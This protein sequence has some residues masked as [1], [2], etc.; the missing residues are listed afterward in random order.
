MTTTDVIS[1]MNGFMFQVG[2]VI[3]PII[4]KVA[5]RVTDDWWN[6]VV[7]N[8]LSYLQRKKV[9]ETGVHDL[10]GLDIASLLRVFDRN[11]FVITNHIFIN[12]RV[13]DGIRS[14]Q[15]IR[16]DWA[17]IAPA[18]VTKEKVLADAE[19]ITNLLQLLGSS[20]GEYRG[21]EQFI[22]SVGKLDGFQMDQATDETPIEPKESAGDNTK[23]EKVMPQSGEITLGSVVTIKSDSSKSGA[24]IGVSGNKYSVFVN[25]AVESYYRE[26][27]ELQNVAIENRFMTLDRVKSA[28]TA[29][30]INNPSSSNLYSLNSARVDFVPYQFRPA[31]KMIQS[32]MPRILVADDV[33]VGKTIEAGFILK[34]M[35]ARHELNSVLVICPRP[36]VAERKWEL[37]M[38]RF[39]ENFTQ[40]NGPAFAQ[41]ISDTDRD[42]EWPEMYS[43]TIIPY[44]L[45]NEDSVMG[46]NSTS[47]KKKKQIGLRDLDPPPHFDLVIVDEAHNIRNS[48]TWMYRAVEI[49]CQNAD[50]VV[51]LTATPLQNS[52]NDLYTLLNLLRPDLVI[53][54]DTFA[55]MSEPNQYINQMLRSARSH[56]E[57]WQE[58]CK[59]EISNILGTSWG[60][61][62]IQHNP[63][64]EKIYD[65]LNL[66]DITREQR[67]ELISLIEGLHSFHSI[68]NRTRRQ[69]IEN[70]CVRRNLTVEVP[71]TGKQRE[72]YE[73]LIEFQRT[74]LTM[75]H[76]AKSVRFMMCTIMRQTA[77]CVYGLA[78]FMDEIVRRNLDR[79]DEQEEFI[80]M[81]FTLNSDDQ[82]YILELSDKINQMAGELPEEDPKFD[83]LMV[84]LQEKQKEEN[85]RVILFSSF[86][87]TLYY[88]ENRLKDEGFRVGRVDGS[89]RDEER[90]RLR[91][92]FQLD[93]NNEDA[94]D[95]LLFSEVGC[96]GLDY[97][98]CDTM[99]N[100][101]L[102][103]NPMR[104]EQR[105]GRIDRRGQKS[106]SIKI[107]NLIT[108]DTI[109][110]TIYNRCLMKIG[111]FEQSIGD[112]SE[113]LGDI[114]EQI[115]KIMFDPELSEEERKVKIEKLADN[116]VMK[117]Q[118]LH[119]LEQQEKSLYGFDL[120][121]YVQNKDVQ[122]A[123]NEWISPQ[124]LQTLINLYLDDYLGKGEYLRGRS[125]E[126]NLQIA[127]E[128]RQLLM[129]DFKKLKLPTVSNEAN[130]WWKSFLKQVKTP[131]LR[132][133]F[134][135]AYARDN[136][137]V[138][139][140]T[141]MHP[142]VIQAARY[143][144]KDYPCNL[145]IR[146]SDG[147]LP[148]GDYEFLIYVWKYEG[149]RPDV[150]LVAICDNPEVEANVLS[151]IRL[152]SEYEDDGKDHSASWDNMDSLHYERWS[153][154]RNRYAGE[155]KAECE[156]RLDQLSHTFN[157]REAIVKRIIE[158]STDEK[159]ILMR[160]AQLQNMQRN[161]EEQKKKVSAAIEKADIQTTLL[162]RGLLHVDV[163]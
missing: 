75:L 129:E 162:V 73:A 142:L 43:K 49:F 149:L 83:K 53:N 140:L 124:S 41:C 153:K 145:A 71:F 30:Q 151:V 148:A 97:Q 79:I 150:K 38:K 88:L 85:N 5:P 141:Q 108:D 4:Q 32:D 106:E 152:A 28:L 154:A 110:A 104:I 84:V 46:K 47:S 121:E 68:I 101:D 12:P 51:F 158:D 34:E 61:N 146:V 10:S 13:R 29:F 67:V 113:I 36:L 143:E 89:V 80:D 161:A 22:M 26:Q 20:A 123:E 105:I 3:V 107:Y 78:P 139:F 82:N 15:G 2:S 132:V 137:G 50:A 1:K 118:E 27:I 69:D 8:N 81:D 122:K 115:L 40:L 91:E 11:W 58:E 25:G 130:R 136:R 147:S 112:C 100:Y 33:G 39:D 19:V 96:E 64:F 99:V 131:N 24:V 72:L 52:N 160:T 92:R 56:G 77:S 35:E 63:D 93:R 54:K 14:M 16:N 98:F 114:S 127:K 163:E 116:E 157:Q 159:I 45:F 119:R 66:P 95:I 155:V 138:T 55:M 18:D 17:H 126:K 87:H 102:P 109:D 133:T 23:A 9:E 60:R 156:Y 117:V 31:L 37:E 76:G 134:D 21:V 65:Y 48:N 62:V 42:G 120:S 59:K 144:G 90:Y 74:V 128:K 125:E 94:L 70:F 135:S 86:R 6:E 111:V 57:E 44:S 7:L 103:W